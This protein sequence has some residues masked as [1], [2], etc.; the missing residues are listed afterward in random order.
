MNVLIESLGWTLLHSLWE[1]TLIWLALR[2]TLV[3]LARRSA[4]LRCTAG[5]AA[6]A[7]AVLGFW[8]TFVQVEV[9]EQRTV[10]TPFISANAAPKEA[11]PNVHPE[12][13]SGISIPSVPGRMKGVV[14]MLLPWLVLFWAI[15]CAWSSVKMAVA[16]RS[17]RR[18][19]RT[20]HLRVSAWLEARF[21]E[22][23]LQMGIGRI[24]QIGES[25]LVDGPSVVG[26][27]KPIV[28][29]PVGAFSGLDPTQIDGLLAHE[30]A[31]VLRHDFAINLLQS[32]C[33]VLFFYHPAISAISQGIRVEREN[34]C[35]DIAVG[36][37]GDPRGYASALAKLEEARCPSAVMAA[38]GGGSL[39]DRVRRLVVAPAVPQRGFLAAS[40]VSFVGV[41]FTFVTV[42]VTPGVTGRL[43]ADQSASSED[44]AG[45]MAADAGFAYDIDFVPFTPQWGQFS[46]GD[47]ISIATVRGNREHLELGGRYL[48]EGTYTLAS[49][50]TAGLSISVTHSS[51]PAP[52]SHSLVDS[53]QGTTVASGSGRFS[54]KITMRYPGEFHVSFNPPGG[55]QSHG[56]VYF[57]EIRQ[58]NAETLGANIAK[59]TIVISI[60]NENFISVNGKDVADELLEPFLVEMHNVDLGASVVVKADEKADLKRLKLVMDSCRRAGLTNIRLQRST[61]VIAIGQDGIISVDDE[62][63]ADGQLEPLL[64]QARNESPD[65]AV[66]IKADE[67]TRL[68]KLSFVM[69]SCREAGLNRFSLQAR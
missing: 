36:I 45:P 42:L 52:G 27:L 18:L 49:M 28:L 55:G 54:L 41:L 66:L 40:W 2:A 69:N 29:V 64:V 11:P 19:V 7:F 59:P 51:I 47:S 8:V 58:A 1:G 4:S 61:L 31:H 21:Q 12:A 20:S 22:L 23:V 13:L 63:V 38:N 26:W 46:P 10:A 39:L 17:A 30:L 68:D 3:I 43:L 24:V 57:G 25:A 65:I 9:T 37:S 15:G 48:V 67:K 56:T 5:C 35:D 62:N 53:E 34:A 60:H 16:W 32:I 50:R 6:L 33:D 14:A 44:S